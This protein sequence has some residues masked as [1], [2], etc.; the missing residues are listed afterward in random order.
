MNGTSK[1]ELDSVAHTLAEAAQF[2]R[3]FDYHL[4]SAIRRCLA[5]C[6]LHSIVVVSD[7]FPDG[8]FIP[9]PISRKRAD[10]QIG[11]MVDEVRQYII[12]YGGNIDIHSLFTGVYANGII[13]KSRIR[14]KDEFGFR[15]D[16]K[17]NKIYFF[18]QSRPEVNAG[19]VDGISKVYSERLA[20]LSS[21]LQILFR[22]R[23]RIYSNFPILL[24]SHYWSSRNDLDVSSPILRLLPPWQRQ[25]SPLM[26]TVA[27][28]LRKSTFAMDMSH[29]AKYFADWVECIV[30]ILRSLCIA[31]LGV[32]DKFTGDG[33]LC[34]FLAAECN[35]F[36]NL[37]E[38]PSSSNLSRASD[39]HSSV[40][41]KHHTGGGSAVVQAL[42]FCWQAQKAA[43]LHILELQRNLSTWQER[44]GF[45][46]GVGLGRN[47]WS[48]DRDGNSIVVGRGVV[49]S[50][51]M[52]DLA[53]RDQI[54][55]SYSLGAEISDLLD[56]EIEIKQVPFVSKEVDV[57]RE[58]LIF[59]VSKPPRGI[60]L[61]HELVRKVMDQSY[62]RFS[63][64]WSRGST[65]K[66]SI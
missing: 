15:D 64:A 19:N 24:S 17:D 4:F 52:A 54:L 40:W 65:T 56:G 30:E 12:D 23:S 8:I 43:S 3:D 55:C 36:V 7:D 20:A 63:G 48:V 33:I 22:Y 14:V 45:G 59:D 57:E 49:Q 10:H 47:E 31:N 29:D 51:R 44:L 42:R 11:E 18:Y 38:L 26:V 35:E 6:G 21:L 66:P 28:D 37:D 60:D 34:H 58:A 61:N 25:S 50:C 5:R 27:V 9:G 41:Q 32:F 53:Y 1:F 16:K 39:W 13:C 46:F 2:E 62:D